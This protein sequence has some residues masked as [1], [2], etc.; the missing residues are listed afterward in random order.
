MSLGVAI[1]GP[2]GIALAADS[3]ITLEAKQA[4]SNMV[5]PVTFD[6]ASKLL[7]FNRP[8][9]GLK[10]PHRFVA[11][12]T[13]GTA[14][15]GT[16]TND[17]RT[18]HSYIPELIGLLGDSRKS[19]IDYSTQISEFFTGQWKKAKMPKDYQGPPMTFV[20]G[21]FDEG[22]AYGKIFLFEIPNAPDPTERSAGEFGI[23]WGGQLE[24][25]ARLMIGFDPSLPGLV[26]RALDLD[27]SGKDKL[28]TALKTLSM[29]VPYSVLPLQDCIDLSTFLIRM[30][31]QAQSLAIGVRGVGGP[32]DVA[33]ITRTEG[34]RFIQRKM[35]HGE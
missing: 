23:T 13:Y 29:P 7:T 26:E 2:D 31:M 6:N 22:E 28:Q 24:F 34:L 20:V 8:D 5:L 35:S 3:R 11:A 21:G 9:L 27:Q 17:L 14:V 16:K 1:K 19:T 25:A 4:K 33:T 30:T 15:I 12:V 18:A 32:I 10:D